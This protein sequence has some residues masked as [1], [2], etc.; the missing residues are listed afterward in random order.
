MAS[1]GEGLERTQGHFRCCVGNRGTA[2]LEPGFGHKN[3]SFCANRSGEN[4]SEQN[5]DRLVQPSCSCHHYGG[6]I[7]KFSLV[8]GA[9]IVFLTMAFY[10]APFLVFF[11]T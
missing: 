6:G 2:V 11:R 5:Y 8:S 7:N 9:A 10:L 1:S 4:S 3:T